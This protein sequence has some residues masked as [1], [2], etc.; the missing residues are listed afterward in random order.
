M[1]QNFKTVRK[2]GLQWQAR[3][4]QNTEPLALL[5]QFHACC[6]CGI[7]LLLQQVVIRCFGL[8]IAACQ[9]GQLLLANR[10]LVQARL[11]AVDLLGERG[12]GLLPVLD[13]DLV[14]L[15]LAL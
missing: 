6:H 8:V 4:I 13:L 15:Q 10:L 7:V 5:Q 9:V 12:D 14:G 11:V 2:A 1:P 3:R